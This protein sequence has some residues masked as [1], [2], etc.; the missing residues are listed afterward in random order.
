[1]DVT[2]PLWG[3]RPI[4]AAA[5]PHQPGREQQCMLG[6][7]SSSTRSLSASAPPN[8]LSGSAPTRPPTRCGVV[9]LS[10]ARLH[11]ILTRDAGLAQ[12]RRSGLF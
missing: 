10:V 8:N 11:Q 1:M 2:C 3:R 9:R 6:A 12:L 4:H 7:A 5:V